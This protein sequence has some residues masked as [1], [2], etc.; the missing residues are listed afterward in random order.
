MSWRN[1]SA[2][3]PVSSWPPSPDVAW[4]RITLRIKDRPAEKMIGDLAELLNYAWLDESGK[5]ILSAGARARVFEEN[6]RRRWYD[7]AAASLLKYVAL[8]E[9]P[10]EYYLGLK[11]AMNEAKGYEIAGLG[12]STLQYL[13]NPA[14]RLG[15]QLLMS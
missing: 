14:R 15:L 7:G 13:A 1:R 3:K 2:L 9:R 5:R 6:E 10:R 12:S 4:D 8:V 11:K